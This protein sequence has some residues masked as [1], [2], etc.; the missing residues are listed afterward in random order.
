MRWCS[1]GVSHEDVFLLVKTFLILKTAKP[2][3]PQNLENAGY[4]TL[5]WTT[6]ARHQPASTCQRNQQREGLWPLLLWNYEF[7][8]DFINVPDTVVSL[9]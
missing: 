8:Y 3:K 7:T 9:P 5:P 2:G 4:T 1:A 6:W